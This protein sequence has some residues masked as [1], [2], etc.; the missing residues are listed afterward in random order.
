MIIITIIIIIII[1]IMLC[2]SNSA[3]HFHFVSLLIG[4]SNKGKKDFTGKLFRS[5]EAELK[6]IFVES[7]IKLIILMHLSVRPLLSIHLCLFF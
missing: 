4:L 7:S 5:I 3:H 6:S 2:I 1:I